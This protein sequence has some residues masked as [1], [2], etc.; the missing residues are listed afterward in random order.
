MARRRIPDQPRYLRSGE[1]A[2][3]FG[4]S[5]KTIT[6]WAREGKLPYRRT[7]GNHRRYDEAKIRELVKLLE[8][9]PD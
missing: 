2:E 3:L 4:V 1:A 9:V 6:R 8:G 7:L 5:A